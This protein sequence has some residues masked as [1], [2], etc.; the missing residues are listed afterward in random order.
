MSKFFPDPPAPPP[1]PPPPPA[2]PIQPSATKAA[3]SKAGATA[4]KRRGQAST[5]TT[6]AEGLMTE[7]PTIKPSLLGQNKVNY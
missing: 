7:A 4:R 2:P 5:I 1:P 3:G 6:G